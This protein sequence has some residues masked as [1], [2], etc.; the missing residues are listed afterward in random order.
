MLNTI[1][2]GNIHKS[3]LIKNG[4]FQLIYKKYII[5]VYVAQSVSIYRN[6]AC[7]SLSQSVRAAQQSENLGIITAYLLSAMSDE[8]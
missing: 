7:M 2:S 8:K 1:V 5:R 3:N 6:Y 4:H